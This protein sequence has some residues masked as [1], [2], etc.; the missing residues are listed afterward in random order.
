MAA[1]PLL[2]GTKKRPGTMC[3]NTNTR[4]TPQ[5]L[6]ECR[7]EYS[8]ASQ[9]TQLD[10]RK[11]RDIIFDPRNSRHDPGELAI[12]SRAERHPKKS[13]QSQI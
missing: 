12:A 4:Y 7:G 9:K 6:L 3:G 5:G 11:Y 1:S 13:T 2:G 8:N 10:M